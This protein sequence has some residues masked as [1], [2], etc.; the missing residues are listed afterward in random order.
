[1]GIQIGDPSFANRVQEGVEND[2]MRK[3]VSSAQGRLKAGRL[4]AAEELGDWE[5]WRTLGAEIRN[6]TMENLDYYLQQLS[7]QVE[8]RGGNVFFAETAEEANRYIQDVVKRKN[9]KKI[10]KSK[11]MVT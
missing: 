4:H 8:K 11:S 3:A 7:D 2:F 6:H 1:M 9:G 10:A 5:D